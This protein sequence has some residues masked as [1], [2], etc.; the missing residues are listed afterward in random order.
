[1]ARHPAIGV[2]E[3]GED[4]DADAAANAAEQQDVAN[5]LDEL[6]VALL[7]RTAAQGEQQDQEQRDEKRQEAQSEEDLSRHHER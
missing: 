3:A 4:D 5:Y 2:T 6:D 7:I 1:M